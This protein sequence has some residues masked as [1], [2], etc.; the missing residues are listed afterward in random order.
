MVIATSI[1]L[2]IASLPCY[3]TS[4]PSHVLATLPLFYFTPCH[5]TSFLLHLPVTSSLSLYPFATLPL[6]HFICLSLYL[7]VTSPS[8]HFTSL[9]LHPL[10]LHLSSVQLLVTLPY[11]QF[12]SLSLHP[13][14]VHFHFI[15]FLLHPLVTSPFPSL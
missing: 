1:H 12:T 6:C 7:L 15:S 8:V 3:S 10:S 14:L 11:L 4:L 13:L 5:F 2:L 9:S